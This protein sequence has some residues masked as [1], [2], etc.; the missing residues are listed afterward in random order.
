MADKQ[1]QMFASASI[2]CA[3]FIVFIHFSLIA[4]ICDGVGHLRRAKGIPTTTD[5]DEPSDDVPSKIDDENESSGEENGVASMLEIRA[6]NVTLFIPE[7]VVHGDDIH[8]SG[9]NMSADFFEVERRN[10]TLGRDNYLR[11]KK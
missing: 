4:Q 11:N 5:L 2:Q 6:K 8:L 7:L 9:V 10:G 3:I 1:F